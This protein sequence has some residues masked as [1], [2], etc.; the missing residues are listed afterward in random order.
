MTLSTRF[1]LWNDDAIFTTLRTRNTLC[2]CR[3]NNYPH[4]VYFVQEGASEVQ[5]Y[6]NQLVTELTNHV[7]AARR[8]GTTSRGT[9]SWL[10]PARA[11][12]GRCTPPSARP[13]PAP[14]AAPAGPSTAAAAPLTAA[15]LRPTRTLVKCSR[16]DRVP[17][18][19]TVYSACMPCTLGKIKIC[20]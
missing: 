5:K 12:P 2:V 8:L 17:D 16:E 9:G 7:R 10:T 13:R 20:C 1:C 6:C 3:W 11:A 14:P 15:T 18:S 19:V 4:L